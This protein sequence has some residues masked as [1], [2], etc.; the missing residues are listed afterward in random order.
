LSM[1]L[2]NLFSSNLKKTILVILDLSLAI[3]KY[4]RICFS[5]RPYMERA[6]VFYETNR[7]IRNLTAQMR[8]MHAENLW[9]PFPNI[10]RREKRHRKFSIDSSSWTCVSCHKWNS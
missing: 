6:F 4:N 1:T 5:V 7:V 10:S 8:F 2:S 9:L 3:F